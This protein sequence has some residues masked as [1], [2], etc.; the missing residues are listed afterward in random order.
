MPTAKWILKDLILKYM[1]L[2]YVLIYGYS[3]T[4]DSKRLLYKSREP[5]IL[6]SEVREKCTNVQAGS[7]KRWCVHM[8]NLMLLLSHWFLRRILF[9][10]PADMICFITEHIPKSYEVI[11]WNMYCRGFADYN[12][13]MFSRNWYFYKKKC[14]MNWLTVYWS[15]CYFYTI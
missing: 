7:L 4:K 8:W 13:F 14:C 9:I 1:F 12:R 15:V 10:S 5:R 6:I 3:K 11:N 2:W